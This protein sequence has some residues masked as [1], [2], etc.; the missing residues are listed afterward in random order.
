MSIQPNHTL[1]ALRAG[2]TVLG[3]ETAGDWRS[4]PLIYAHAGLDFIWI[5][6]EHAIANPADVNAT[7]QS[8]RLAG[9]TPI[10]RVCAPEYARICPLLDNGAQGIIVPRVDDPETVARVVSFTRFPPEGVRGCGN[11]L[12]AHDYRQTSIA[13]HVAGSAEEILVA[14]QAESRR[15]VDAIDEIVAVAGLDLVIIG[16]TDL[17]ISLGHPGELD[18]PEVI[19]HCER[20]IEAGKARGI[21]VGI[22]GISDPVYWARQGVRFVQVFGDADLLATESQRRTA[23]LREGIAKLALC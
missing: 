16:P 6:T 7:I 5:D 15:A 14:V 8:C 23:E 17:S 18:H 2:K 3:G 10:V 13:D 22:A 19:G 11:P 20:V 4:V 21:A 9:I 12:Y 1:R